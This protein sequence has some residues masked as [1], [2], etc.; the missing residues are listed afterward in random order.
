MHLGDEILKIAF[1]TAVIIA[2]KDQLL[3]AFRTIPARIMDGGEIRD[4]AGA[5]PQDFHV[6]DDVKGQ[7]CGQ[8][9]QH[10]GLECTDRCDVVLRIARQ[11]LH[12]LHGGNVIMGRIAVIRRLV[13]LHPSQPCQR[14][15]RCGQCQQQRHHPQRDIDIRRLQQGDHAKSHQPHRQQQRHYRESC[16]GFQPQP[17]IFRDKA[18]EREILMPR[19]P[20]IAM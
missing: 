17:R 14:N 9:P 10:T 19:E 15:A 18:G 8:P 20:R 4:K 3:T 5:E 1:P 7:R 11:I 6:F 2:L 13:R 12:L 16:Q